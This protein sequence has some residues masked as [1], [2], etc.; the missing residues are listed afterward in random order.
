MKKVFALIL[1]TFTLKINAQNV[2]WFY[3]SLDGSEVIDLQLGARNNGTQKIFNILSSYINGQSYL[4]TN[5]SAWASWNILTRGSSTGL[6]SIFRVGGS[7][8]SGHSIV[9]YDKDD[10]STANVYFNSNGDSFLSEGNFGI[11]TNAPSNLLE[12]KSSSGS[13]NAAVE[14]ENDQNVSSFLYTGRSGNSG[15]AGKTVVENALGNSILLNPS[16]GNVGIGTLSPSARLD[17]AGDLHLSGG[18][19]QFNRVYENFGN[20]LNLRTMDN[21]QFGDFRFEAER[22]DDGQVRK[23]MY[24]DGG[25]GGLGI[26]TENVPDGYRLAVD[27]KGIFEEVKVQISQEWPDYVFENDYDLMSLERTEHYIIEN[28]HLPEMPSKDEVVESGID[29]GDM[30]VRLLKKIEE[31]TLHQ[32]SLLKELKSQRNRIEHLEKNIEELSAELKVSQIKH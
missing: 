8:S 10:G 6:K 26:G 31:L 23:L 20:V 15:I 9:L 7:G 17:V 18:L 13:I 28:R 5:T 25:R 19:I 11:G 2:G 27:G 3:G 22:T 29:I 4:T 12:I 16:N 1:L 21:N 24:L 30:N 14:S 32:I